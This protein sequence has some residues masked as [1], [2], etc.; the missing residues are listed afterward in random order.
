[1]SRHSPGTDSGSLKHSDHDSWRWKEVQGSTT[2]VQ[3]WSVRFV[4]KFIVPQA[5]LDETCCRPP[6]PGL[7]NCP[8]L[9]YCGS[10]IVL[11][12]Q[13]FP[14][15]GALG[16]LGADLGPGL[17]FCEHVNCFSATFWFLSRPL[18]SKVFMLQGLWRGL[19][20][21]ARRR[22]TQPTSW[23]NLPR[24]PGVFMCR[25][26]THHLKSQFGVPV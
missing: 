19:T 1:M 7:G 11:L 12:Y 10:Q 5:Y 22:L 2:D 14:W 9:L 24:L 6:P 8:L 20:R 17:Q 13:E 4:N 26:L 15:T 3:P 23:L 16:H 25:E 18:N 21:V